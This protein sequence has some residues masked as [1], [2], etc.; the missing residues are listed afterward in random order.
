M[1]AGGE[2]LSRNPHPRPIVLVPLFTALCQAFCA[3]LWLPLKFGH[4]S[5]IHPD[6]WDFIQRSFR[7]TKAEIP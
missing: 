3:A 6:I 1:R 4:E 7:N 2:A 5:N